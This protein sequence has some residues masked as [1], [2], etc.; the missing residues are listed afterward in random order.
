MK[1]LL[2]GCAAGEGRLDSTDANRSDWIGKT[3]AANLKSQARKLGTGMVVMKEFHFESRSSLKC[4][5]DHG[6]ARVPSLPMTRLNIQYQ[7]FEQYMTK[8]L[9]K[10]T[11]KGLRRKFRDAA[12]G[13]AI[14]LEVI[15]NVTPFVD[16]IYPLYRAVYERSPLH[17]ETLTKEYFIRLGREMPD[18]VRYFLWR[19]NGKTIAFSL[20]MLSGQT[21]YD[22][23]L[24]LD[25]SVALKLHLYFYT[26][27]DILEWG[28]RNGYQW[29]CSSALNYDPKLHLRCK[30]EPLD[31]YVGHTWGIINFFLTRL[32]PILEPTHN[33]KTL[34]QFANYQQLW[35]D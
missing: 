27:R 8:A 22:E 30:L 12:A 20:V 4:F 7:D 35:K 9:S 31:L 26:L 33:D 5:T 17:F 2:V 29:Y 23:Y 15:S 19:Q 34:K 32:L 24:G 28:M 6:F 3:L 16:E 18:K 13:E 11:R 10:V 25:Y 14:S 1:T 21:I